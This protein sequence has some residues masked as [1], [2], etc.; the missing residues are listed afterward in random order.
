M[1]TKQGKR[2]KDFDCTGAPDVQLNLNVRGLFPSAT[3]AINE[4]SD[5][6]I[7]KGRKIFKMGLGQSPFPVPDVLEQA[8]KENAHQKD[9]LPVRG[10]YALREAIANQHM[11]EFGI[12]CDPRDILVGPGSKELM[13]ILQLAYYGD[14][15]I[16]TPAWVSYAPQAKI[17]G[18]QI[19]FLHTHPE[20]NWR[21]MPFQIEKLCESDPGRPRIVIL[22]YPSNPTGATYSVD[23]LK[24]LAAVARKYKLIILSDEIYGKLHHQG[25][26]QSIVPYYPEG[27]IL[28]S[29]LS[30]WC[31]AGGWRLGMFVF[32]EC[33]RW[34][35]DAMSVIA[36]ET[37][38]STSAPIQHAAIKGFQ[39]DEQLDRYLHVVRMIL[40]ALGKKLHTMLKENKLN[41]VFPLGGFYLFP[42]FSPLSKKIWKHNIK[43]SDALCEKILEDTGVAILPGRD[44][45]RP[46]YELTARLAYVNFDGTLALREGMKYYD[47]Q[48]KLDDTFLKNYC[49][50][51]LEAVELLCNWVSAL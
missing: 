33:L 43:T 7:K 4:R 32:P 44:F 19:H 36:S 10:L 38:T 23:E 46:K 27:T 39:E 13:F 16:P 47:Q 42:D 34:L 49:A 45:G 1:K 3:V 29:G 28:S 2:K 37:F 35:S 14:I 40:G 18:R 22:N 9:Y 8:L 12:V 25:E 31:G 24:Q 5:E 30:K 15:I 41:V 17:I 20:N 6:L 48:K 50:E 26:H 21:L 51:P 11:Q